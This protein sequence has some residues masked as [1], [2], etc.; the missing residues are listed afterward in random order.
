M[1]LARLE[2]DEDQ[3]LDAKD[4][5]IMGGRWPARNITSSLSKDWPS[6]TI[7]QKKTTLKNLNPQSVSGVKRLAVDLEDYGQNKNDDKNDCRVEKNIEEEDRIG[8]SGPVNGAD[9][10]SEQLKIRESD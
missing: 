6:A 1:R 7:H 2:M 8:K 4:N 5:K 10:F 9:Q 3:P